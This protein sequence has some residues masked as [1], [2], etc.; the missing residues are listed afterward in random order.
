VLPHA[1]VREG[2]VV[3]KTPHPFEFVGTP[4]CPLPQGERARNATAAAYP[5]CFETP[6]IAAKL[7]CTAPQHEGER[8]ESTRAKEARRFALLPVIPVYEPRRQRRPCLFCRPGFGAAEGCCLAD[9]A[10]FELQRCLNPGPGHFQQDLAV[11]LRLGI[12]GPTQTLLRELTQVFGRYCHDAL[13]TENR[14]ERDRSLSHRRL[15]ASAAGDER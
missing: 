1:M 8:G 9:H 6:R 11:P 2:C 10:M 4:L 7:R 14:R 5:S 13:R 15:H 3:A 12:A